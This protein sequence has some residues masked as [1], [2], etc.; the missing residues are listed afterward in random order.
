VRRR[1]EKEETHCVSTLYIALI[2]LFGI[3]SQQ[4]QI[5]KFCNTFCLFARQEEVCLTMVDEAQD[6]MKEAVSKA[7]DLLASDIENGVFSLNG[8]QVIVIT[9]SLF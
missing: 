4:E 8:L 3:M 1:A 2:Y 9:V 6:K 5:S 7:A